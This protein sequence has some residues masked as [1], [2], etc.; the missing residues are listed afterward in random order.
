MLHRLANDLRFRRRK[1]ELSQ[2][3]VVR[4]ANALNG[5][6]APFNQAY[7]SLIERGM[8]PRSEKDVQVLAIV[9]GTTS[10]LS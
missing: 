10:P 8:T 7:L 3:E 4:R 1:L 6:G 9:L 5:S 2:A